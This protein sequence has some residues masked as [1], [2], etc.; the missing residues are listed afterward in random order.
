MNNQPQPDPAEAL[1]RQTRESEKADERRYLL[2]ALKVRQV[3][4]AKD[5]EAEVRK[6]KPRLFR[7]EE[8]QIRV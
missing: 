7:E 1:H 4:A 2:E 5:A 3:E 8:V 6:H